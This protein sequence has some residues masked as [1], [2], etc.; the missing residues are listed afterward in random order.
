MSELLPHNATGFETALDD[1][2]ARIGAVPV[3][4][5]DVWDPD[6]CPE[7]VL[8]WLAWALSID[9]WNTAWTAQQKRDA[10]KAAILVQK[11]KGTIGAVR[12]GLSAIDLDTRVVEWH[13]EQTPG[14]P[15]T[16]RLLIDASANAATL[17]EILEALDTI[18]RV[19]SLRSHMTEVQV[20]TSTV[21]GPYVVAATFTGNEISVVDYQTPTLGPA[22][23]W[24]DTADWWDF[25]FW[26]LEP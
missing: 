18:E 20:S 9:Q 7:N 22:T 16:Y 8:P 5:R 1:V 19:K 6:T 13:R 21:A 25:A 4:V 12:A 14:A 24:D 15:Y 26:G 3:R 17:A 11:V 23:V 2:T 10:I